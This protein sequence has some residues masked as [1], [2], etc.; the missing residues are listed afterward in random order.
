M[1]LAVVAF[2]SP[3]DFDPTDLDHDTENC[4]HTDTS[5]S[6]SQ[7]NESTYFAETSDAGV[8][9]DG[10]N[11]DFEDVITDD[12]SIKVGDGSLGAGWWLTGRVGRERRR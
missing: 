6:E 11:G 4:G 5:Y 2:T 12:G 1:H 9:P 8:G 3:Q 7:G 10:E